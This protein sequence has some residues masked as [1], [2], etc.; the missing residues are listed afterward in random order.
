MSQY[1]PIPALA[2]HA[3]LGRRITRREYEAV[4]NYALDLGFENIF[5]QE[6]SDHHLSP[7][8]NKDDP[9]GPH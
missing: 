9:F 4:V 6:V 8:F 7:D 2:R 1:T 3:I 5:A